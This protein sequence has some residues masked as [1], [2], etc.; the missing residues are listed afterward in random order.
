VLSTTTKLFAGAIVL[1][2]CFVPG[3]LRA[4][5]DSALPL[6]LS[7]ATL[8]DDGR[9]AVAQADDL[10]KAARKA[11]SDGNYEVA[12]AK[13]AAAEKLQPKY[14]PIHI[15]DTPKKARIDLDKLMAKRGAAGDANV[16]GKPDRAAQ[17]PV[18]PFQARQAQPSAQMAAGGG[19]PPIGASS[20]DVS[21]ASTAAAS[22]A[23]ASTPVVGIRTSGGAIMESLAGGLQAPVGSPSRSIR[24]LAEPEGPNPWD[25][26]GP[27]AG[28]ASATASTPNQNI[29]RGNAPS[30]DIVAQNQNLARTQSDAMLLDARRMLARGDA[31]AAQMKV[32]QAKGLGVSY[33]PMDDSPAKLEALIRKFVAL[34]PAT[35]ADNEGTRRRRAE[36]WMEEAESLIRWR[37]YNEA[38]RLARDTQRLG[39]SYSPFEAKPEQLL[40]RI[41]EARQAAGP[42]S[43]NNPLAAG[44]SDK[45]RASDLARQAR[46]AMAQ[47]DLAAAEQM[48]RQ[49]ETLAPDTAFGPGE[50]RP[51]L[52]LLD[53][54]RAKTGRFPVSRAGGA[55]ITD[56]SRY[57]VASAV[58]DPANDKTHNI[59]ANSSSGPLPSLS[60]PTPEGG[61]G[62]AIRSYRLGMEAAARYS[63][64]EALANF[65]HAYA[66][67]MEL[68]P[69]TRK[70]L[71]D[72]LRKLGDPVDSSSAVGAPALTA[73]G[74][75]KPAWDRLS[76]V[77][78]APVSANYSPSSPMAAP[79]LISPGAVAAV[80]PPPAAAAIPSPLE[81]VPSPAPPTT[82]G[83][84][85]ARQVANE[86]AR[87]QSL[88][89]EIREKQPK[90]ALET[91]Q[92]TRDMVANVSGLDPGARDQLLKRLDMTIAD[93]QQY[94]AKN[95][96]QIELDER[97]K[98]IEQEVD[99]SRKQKVVVQEKLAYL[100]NDFN[101][102]VDEQRYA[103]AQL[104][105]KKATE[106]DPDNP[107]V[108]QL[109][110]MSRA[111]SRT[112]QIE[113][114]RSAQEQG[115]IDVL[116]D[117][118]KA[119]EPFK[120]P[121]QMPDAKKWKQLSQT[122]LARLR[123]GTQRRSPKEMEIAQ[124][125]NTPVDAKYQNRPLH[126]VLDGLA[127]RASVPLYIDPQGLQS[128][129]VS[130]DAKVTIDLSQDISLKS[131]LNLIL[132]QFHLTY[133]IKDEVLKITSEDA[134][135]GEVYQIIYPV[136]D[137]VIPIPNF[138]PSGREGINGAFREAYERM[139]FSGAAG[140]AGLGGAGPITLA[141]NE[142]GA[143]SSFAANAGVL[144]QMQQRPGIPIFGSGST[145]T[146]AQQNIPFGPGGLKGGQ[147]ADF[148]SLIDLITSTI[149]QESWTDKGGQ[150][151]ISPFNTNLSLVISQTQEVHEK[152]SDLLQQLRRL[153]DLQV[154]IEVRF[155][156]LEDDFFEKMGIDFD[157]NIPSATTVPN[158]P[159]VAGPPPS[160]GPLSPSA[161]VG[162]DPGGNITP[163]QD[164]QFRQGGFGAVTPPFGGFDAGSAATF[165]FAVLSD[166]Q[167][168]FVIQAAQG[169]TRSNILQAPKVT[170]FNGQQASIADQTQ[171]PFVTSVIPVVGDFAAALQPVIVVLSQGT[172]LTV[173]AVVSNDRRFVR[174]TVVPFF[175]QIG[176]VDT[177]TFSGSS[178]TTK[179]SS[180][181]KSGSS[182][183]STSKDDE[184][185]STGTTVQLPQFSFVTVT[186]TVS[187]PDGGTVLLGGIKRLNEGR[188]ERGVPI[189]S[190]LPYINRLFRNTAIG[191]ETTSLMMMVT[192]RI[193][194]QEEEEE[195][196]LGGP[197]QP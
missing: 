189:L 160:F 188:T 19:R 56:P 197:P 154:T 144:A 83:Q 161:V 42:A 25:V 57:P 108:V 74:G 4:G 118:D 114:N 63:R 183:T 151:S 125:L 106:L 46:L 167:A 61:T 162:L 139:G 64:D 45:Q 171:V 72:E 40:G 44:L 194:I 8:G 181:S 111:L 47:G 10:L 148:D 153:Q 142:Q 18:D 79:G 77:S 122:R 84:A 101:K 182:D 168:F 175:S 185:S 85:L 43:G 176:D 58:Y 133:V 186:T 31:R 23:V 99:S 34:P 110:V 132:E 38:E 94:V 16:K 152:I 113:D 41:A 138:A 159:P 59:A 146:G 35:A 3:R 49:G 190:K 131:A 109:N 90:Q 149:E 69:Q 166:I 73:A 21:D 173:Q 68:D 177:F 5:V 124:R 24:S 187:V 26:D 75:T 119:A 196:L 32:D 88:A 141:T 172:S 82:S 80:S 134:K 143:G 191:R 89:R 70:S 107:V 155:I 150:G 123:D 15:G 93:F 178:S 7:A 180:D 78:T 193:I 76:T 50:D 192:P 97:N 14:P 81:N 53:V 54:Q 145:S 163:L 184:T 2:A 67:Q 103:D 37:E 135:R 174:L 130:S 116:A 9:G 36:V 29:A 87:Q 65:R 51:A 195:N 91:L 12:D 120:G 71:H 60:E 86:V 121:I 170:L 28:A 164:I 179:K 98:K 147:Q 100:V 13:I 66:F 48:A 27:P 39:I 169:D 165:G 55:T 22:Q 20:L 140:G 128:E 112:A 117:V 136:G 30:T 129:G 102:A 17:L 105:A 104:L 6:V 52:V 115:F 62:E 157:F 1:A 96:P 156:T 95:G 127:K 92:R 11:M 126:E 158:P 33:S 137:L